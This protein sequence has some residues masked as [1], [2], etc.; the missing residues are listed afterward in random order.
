MQESD[1]RVSEPVNGNQDPVLASLTELPI[2]DNGNN[3]N[4]VILNRSVEGQLPLTLTLSLLDPTVNVCSAC[5]KPRQQ[6]TSD[7]M[8]WLWLNGHSHNICPR[9][10]VTTESKNRLNALRKRVQRWAAKT[11]V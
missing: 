5:L 2:N 1:T 3:D 9:G 4:Q 7:G 8:P 10:S 6:R 11:H